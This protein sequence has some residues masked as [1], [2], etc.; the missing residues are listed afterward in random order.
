MSNM[1]HSTIAQ[2]VFEH[3]P[4]LNLPLLVKELD[5]ALEKSGAG[6]RTV[7]WDCDDLALLDVEGARFTLSYSRVP[8]GQPGLMISVGPRPGAGRARVDPVRHASLCQVIAKRLQDRFAPERMLWH[9][10]T[11][12]VT[13][14]LIDDLF[15]RL[16]DFD[17]RARLDSPQLRGPARSAANPFPEE[18]TIDTVSFTEKAMAI[19]AAKA[20][21]TGHSLPG[22][23]PV[24]AND[25]PDLPRAR[26]PSEL[27]AV[28]S[29]LY[30]DPDNTTETNPRMRLAAHTMDA[31][32][33]VVA[34][35][36]GAAMLTYSLLRGGN[37]NVSARMMAVTCTLLGLSQTP[38]GSQML[39]MI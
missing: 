11:G 8:T 25:R 23:N 3:D 2:F 22:P 39:A 37:V 10:V 34:L 29:A 4:A 19:R 30:P 12:P 21:R 38:I 18:G 36:V 9:H 17:R 15:D 1:T 32:L 31:T 35:P 27:D 33:I 13:A 6:R 5:A 16:P 14:D 20:A 28:R 24:P 7:T 26:P